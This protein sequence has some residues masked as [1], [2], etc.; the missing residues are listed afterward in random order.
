MP[1][2]RNFNFLSLFL[3]ASGILTSSLSADSVDKPPKLFPDRTCAVFQGDSITHGGRGGDPNHAI[4]HSY[5]ILIAAPQA[6][7][8]PEAHFQFHNRGVSGN[9]VGSLVG[10]WNNDT[11]ALKPDVVSILIGVND[12]LQ[13]V[14]QGHPFSI[15]DFEGSY[16][17]IL[18]ETLKSNPNVRFVLCEPFIEHGKNTDP[19][20]NEDLQAVQQMQALVSKL[21]AEYKAPVVHLQKV[22][23]DAVAVYHPV[24]YWVW[25]GI[26]PTFAGHQL[27]ADAWVRA[28]S[29]FYKFQN[30]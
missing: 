3:V 20:W 7:Y 16:R 24:D 21:A 19:F 5:V 28:Y 18:A 14:N 15:Q 2:Y 6:A 17:R 25:D 4:G 12:L 10:R 1:R 11:L 27:I 13:T 9:A 23:D 30:P 8:Y 26:H 29:E 22:F